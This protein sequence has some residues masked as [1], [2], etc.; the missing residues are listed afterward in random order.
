MPVEFNI[1]PDSDNPTNR[2]A[3]ERV[4]TMLP[5]LRPLFGEYPFVNEKYGIYQFPFGGGME[6]Q[7]NS[8]QG[9]FDEGVTV[10]E[11]GHQ[12]WGDD[13]TCKTWN[14][15]WLNEGFASYTEA[16][17]REYRP[18]NA[19]LDS[20]QAFMNQRRP[21]SLNGSVYVYT[22]NDMNRIFSSN[23]SYRKGSWVLHTLRG[24]I[25][26]QA[27]FSTLAAYRAQY[28]GSAATTDQFRAVAESVS[29]Q[30]LESFFDAWVYGIGAP[31][32]VTGIQPVTI[33][34]TRWVRVS[35]QQ[36]QDTSWGDGGLFAGPLTL[37]LTTASSS[38]D[39]RVNNTARTQ[40]YLL[41]AVVGSDTTSGIVVDPRDWVLKESV[42]VGSYVPGPVKVVN[43]TPAPGSTGAIASNQIRIRLSDAVTANASQFE[44]R[45]SGNVVAFSFSQP[46]P[47]LVVLTLAQP[48]QGGSYS[49]RVDSSVNAS[50]R[51]LDGEVLANALPSGDGLAGGSAL[52]NFSVP[53]CGSIDFNGDGLFPDDADLVDFLAV[54]AGGTC[55]TSSCDSIDFNNDG[56]FP[57]DEDLI[58]FLR[59][60][61][62]GECV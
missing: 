1:Y 57:D 55:S 23:F 31:T 46:E 53:G 19:G 6:H 44:V 45:R 33:D 34:G 60:L 61:A 3:W 24:A 8:G 40:H 16:L 7:T 28:T 18:G 38:R 17:W 37:R 13:V 22:S 5:T 52:W 29:G 56:L 35:L 25:G 41:P 39:A 12:W 59:V 9:T 58:A 27:F 15:I 21:T 43:A 48:A 32:Y 49:V 47:S 4:M 10:H 54:L 62:G 30:N 11:L 26:D 36:T 51:L 14:D 20:L 42:T 50:G 2:A